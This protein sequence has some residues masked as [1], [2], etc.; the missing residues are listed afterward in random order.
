[1]TEHLPGTGP[2]GGQPAGDGPTDGE[3]TFA[4]AMH[5]VTLVAL[6]TGGWLLN[7]IVPLVGMLWK[8]D[9]SAFVREHSREQLNFQIS[10][11]IYSVI[12]VVLVVLTLGIGLLA[13]V[14]LAI[15]LGIVVLVVMVIA[16][17][18]ANRGEHYRFPLTIRLVR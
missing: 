4:M 7:V 3:R 18:A 14:P 5:V 9:T 11:I 8:G 10:L 16:A 17:L 15:I 6:L 12:A 2:A 1:M 13:I